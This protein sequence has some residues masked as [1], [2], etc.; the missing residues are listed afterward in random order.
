MKILRS[1][2]S[3][4]AVAGAMS[5]YAQPQAKWLQAFPTSELSTRTWDP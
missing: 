3:I 4:C 5:L 2:L 1:I